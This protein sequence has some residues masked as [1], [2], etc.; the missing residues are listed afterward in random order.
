[1]ELDWRDDAA[2]KTA[3]VEIFFPETSLA[4]DTKPALEFCRTCPVRRECL[5]DALK[6]MMEEDLGIR[7]GLGP[8]SRRKLRSPGGRAKRLPDVLPKTEYTCVFNDCNSESAQASRYCGPHYRE[9]K[10]QEAAAKRAEQKAATPEPEL[11]KDGCAVADCDRSLYS[12]GLC[13]S[14]YDQIARP[15]QL[16]ASRAKPK[17]PDRGCTVEGCDRK[18]RALGLCHTH[19]SREFRARQ[20]ALRPKPEPKAKPEPKPLE[21]CTVEGCR[22]L[23]TARGLCMA[24]YTR[25]RRG[26]PLNTP[27]APSRRTE[28]ECERHGCKEPA[29]KDRLCRIHIGRLAAKQ[30]A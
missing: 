17:R 8:G 11:V 23:S 22:N 7:G 26:K 9:M 20:A 3:D 18:H 19:Y 14:H 2:C 5:A 1:M 28:G 10:K 29:H 15:K 4:A 12:K 30:Y 24:H 6:T 13:R 27:L 21:N 16:R 25:L